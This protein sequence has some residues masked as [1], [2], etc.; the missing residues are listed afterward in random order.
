MRRIEVDQHRYELKALIDSEKPS[1]GSLR[2]HR[3]VCLE[4]GQG[5]LDAPGRRVEGYRRW[6]PR[7]GEVDGYRIS[8]DRLAGYPKLRHFEAEGLHARQILKTYEELGSRLP[9]VTMHECMELGS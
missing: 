1:N 3:Q 5:R 9:T 2:G 8:K 7:R 4:Q 6:L